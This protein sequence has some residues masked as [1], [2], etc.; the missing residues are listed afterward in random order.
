MP[1]IYW[2]ALT[3]AAALVSV[4]S[5]WAYNRW[6]DHKAKLAEIQREA[7]EQL[8]WDEDMAEFNKM[9]AQLNSLNA[10]ILKV[11]IANTEVY[12]PDEGRTLH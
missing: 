6:Q 3:V 8:K 11:E 2:L 4:G 7:Q 12:I 5:I 9:L 10:A 1:A